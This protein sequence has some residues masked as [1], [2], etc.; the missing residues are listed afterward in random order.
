M[1]AVVARDLV[2]GYG[3]TIALDRSSFE[4]PAGVVSAVIG[5]N[6][7][8]KSTLLNGIASLIDPTSGCT[9]LPPNS[10]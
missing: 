9:P 6:G 3:S 4:I 1:A 8:G 5:P 10:Q 7:S 2:L